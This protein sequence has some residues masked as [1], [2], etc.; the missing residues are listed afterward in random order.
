VTL[1]VDQVRHSDAGGD[2][3]GALAAAGMRRW[4]S[5]RVALA[6]RGQGE[7]P[8]GSPR[9]AWAQALR[10]LSASDAGEAG[11]ARSVYLTACWLRRADIDSYAA[12]RPENGEGTV[13]VVP[14]ITA[15]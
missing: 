5:A 1:L 3:I 4:R 14:E 10:R 8:A 7:P 12:A 15:G 9:Q 6:A 13:D 2:A 11:P